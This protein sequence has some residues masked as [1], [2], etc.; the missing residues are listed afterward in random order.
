MMID[1]ST[2]ML[3]VSIRSKESG[4]T[5][6]N[7]VLVTLLELRNRQPPMCP[8]SL[9]TLWLQKR[10]HGL[11]RIQTN[12]DCLPESDIPPTFVSSKAN[13]QTRQSPHPFSVGSVVGVS[14]WC[15]Q[16]LKA[17][18]LFSSGKSMHACLLNCFSCVQLFATPWIVAH[19]VPPSMGFSRQEYW[20]GLSFSSPGSFP[21]P[22]TKP[23]SPA[24][25]A[26]SLP[27]ELPG[28]AH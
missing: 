26:D 16:K 18:L 14:V 11:F 2:W 24:L 20:S 1:H 8:S 10:C 17:L 28:K 19:Q 22:G 21:D 25:Q 7:F 12:T 13:Q 4:C 9:C 27:S 23:G 6:N 3:L 15:T 5:L